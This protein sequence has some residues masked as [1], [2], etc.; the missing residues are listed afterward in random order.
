VRKKNEKKRKNKKSGKR[1]KTARSYI[2]LAHSHG[3]KDLELCLAGWL[4]GWLAG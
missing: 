2:V 1:E 4:A 3:S